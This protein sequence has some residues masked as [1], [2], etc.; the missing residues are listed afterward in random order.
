MKRFKVDENLPT[1][2]V[3]QLQAAGYNA[4]TV[5]TEGLAGQPDERVFEACQGEQRVLVTLDRGFGDIRRYAPGSHAGIIVLRPARQ[6]RELCSA[7]LAQVI[8]LLQERDVAG[9]I[10]IVEWG[11]VRVRS[12]RDD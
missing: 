4:E 6:D 3:E 9:S 7:L 2:L 1:E 5:P 11:R 10:W 12:K 8:P